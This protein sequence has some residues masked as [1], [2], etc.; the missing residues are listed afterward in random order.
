[1][2]VRADFYMIAG[3]PQFVAQPLLLVCKLAAK[4]VESSQPCLIFCDSMEQAEFLDDL[5]WEFEPDS[6]IPHQI[7]GSDDDEDV[8][9][10]PVLED[11]LNG[12]GINDH[13]SSD[14]GRGGGNEVVPVEMLYQ[15]P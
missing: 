5:L 12:Q 9:D 7:I 8:D 1:M 10:T 13:R 2:S 11:P 6:F 14:K 15:E 3:K 4:A